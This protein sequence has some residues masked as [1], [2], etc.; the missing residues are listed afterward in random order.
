MIQ[1]IIILSIILFITII[2]YSYILGKT[3]QENKQYKSNNKLQR[4][5]NNVKNI[6][7][8]DLINKLKK[9]KF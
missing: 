5:I 9:G 6:S 8:K 2:Y 1:Y 7:K 3:K 4:K